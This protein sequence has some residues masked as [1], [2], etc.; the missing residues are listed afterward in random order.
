MTQRL[1]EGLGIN[2]YD[3]SVGLGEANQCL[4]YCLLDLKCRDTYFTIRRTFVN[5]LR[6]LLYEGT[7][8]L[9][10]LAGPGDYL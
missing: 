7:Y 10:R 1:L 5:I 3:Y 6:F 8:R 9:D 4:T 2:S